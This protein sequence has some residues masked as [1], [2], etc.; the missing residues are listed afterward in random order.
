MK[1]ALLKL[2][3]RG[4]RQGRLTLIEHT[5]AVHEFGAG[6][7]AANWRLHQPNTLIRILRNPQVNL[8]ETYL[9]GD[10]DTDGGDLHALLTLLRIN[11]EAETRRRAWF[12]PILQLMAAGNRIAASR[13]NAAHHYDLD[14]TL[15][16]ACLD[17]NLHY[18]CAYFRTPD[19]SLEAAQ[20]AKCAHIARKLRLAPG[21]SVLDIGSGWGGLGLYLAERHEAQVTGLTLSAEQLRVARQAASTRG[22]GQQVSFQLQDYR[23]HAGQYDRIVSV[24][25]FEHVGKRHFP[26]FFRQLARCLKPDG[27]ALLHTIAGHGPPQPI[28]PWI[29][30]YIFPGGYIPALSDIAP[31]I[32][33]AGLITTDLELLRGHYA[34][35]LRAWNENFQ[36]R[37]SSIRVSKGERFCRLWEF[38][39]V[40]CQTAFEVSDLLVQ[41]WQ[42]THRQLSVPITRDYLYADEAPS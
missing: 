36:R 6:S 2:F 13:K 21:Q 39:L 20:E 34:Q 25:M 16:R 18:S 31:E 42:L 11:L 29:R 10:W 23:Q 4:I 12:Q 5:G 32:E 15:F 26:A 3:E 41:Q 19:L 8:G 38:Y 33:K 27:I 1:T 30:R 9:D 24:G 35:T 37:R 40:S 17:S 7:P 14:E 28:N 22:L